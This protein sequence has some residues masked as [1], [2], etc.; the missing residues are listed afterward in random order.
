MNKNDFVF[1]GDIAEALAKAVDANLPY[2]VYNLGS[3]YATSVYDV[4][5]IVEKRL[6][7][8]ETIASQVLKKGQQA[9]TVN[10]C[11]DMEKT[12]Q[13]LGIKCDTSFEEGIKLYIDYIHSK[14]TI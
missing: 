4:C 5:R 7:G 8:T 3:G 2:G 6:L 12:G 14:G 9:E 10:F 13:A 1:V 11:A